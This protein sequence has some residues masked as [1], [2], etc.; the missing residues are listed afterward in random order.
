M[1][2]LSLYI[3]VQKSEMYPR[4]NMFLIKELNLKNLPVNYFY[5]S[6]TSIVLSMTMRD[7][8]IFLQNTKITIEQ[9]E[10]V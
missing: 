7:L 10:S 1:H 9:T 8:I 2:S 5:S 6:I 4:F 3:F